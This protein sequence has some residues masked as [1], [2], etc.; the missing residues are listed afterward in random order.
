MFDSGISASALIDDLK[1]EVDIAI[2]VPDSLYL[3]WLSSLEQMLYTEIIQEQHSVSVSASDGVISLSEIPVDDEQDKIRFEDIYAFYADDTQY[4]KST[5]TSGNIF[6]ETYY[7]KE[8]NVAYNAPEPPQNIKIIY[9]I[10]PALK[11]AETAENHVCVPPEFIDLVKAK[12]RGEA[13]KIANEDAIAAKWLN[14]YNV[15]LETFK[16]WI[17]GKAPNFGM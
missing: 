5:L 3:S 9:F 2:P 1:N 16:V 12:L 13:Y 10:R 7:K 15:L 17:A 11:T 8:N 14:D 4:I 6:P